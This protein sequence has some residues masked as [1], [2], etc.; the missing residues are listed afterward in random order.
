M[1]IIEIDFT[2]K[3]LVER[4]DRLFE[5]CPNAFI[6]QS[7]YWSNVIKDLG[8][9]KPIFLLCENAG[10]DVAAL[11]LYLYEHEL[12]NIM[13]SIP[14]PGPLGGI[15][16]REDTSIDKIHEIYMC[17]LLKA[18]EIAQH[19][20]CMSLTFITN[21]F[22]NDIDFYEKYLS[23]EFVFENFTQYIPLTQSVH[24]SH[25]HR[26]NLNKAKKFGFNVKFCETLEEL[27]KWYEIHNKRH[28]EIGTTP[29]E[30][31]LFENMFQQLVTRH[32]AQLVLVKDDDEIASG[33]FYIYHRRVLDV[34]MLSLNSEYAK[35]APNYSN[36]D[37][38]VRWAKELGIT[39]F[40]WQSSPNKKC[41]VYQYKKQWG[42]VDSPYYF[43]TK[44]L[45]D[46]RTIQEIGIDNLK[47]QY[48][49]HYVLPYEVFKKGFGKKYFKKE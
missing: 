38:S 25:G 17:L 19:N 26:N 41:G 9:D 7:T 21:P 4:Y 10:Q 43:V 37:Y 32:K 30:Y 6:Q 31:C 13:T 28:V 33:A 16:H 11:P 47:Q 12:G 45:C 20:H 14:Q 24:R 2:D 18:V 8:P 46:P 15:F 5:E 23:P 42:S 44:I 3:R 35:F 29:L 34:F 1:Q 39:I 48:E 36:T 40:N 22:N 27:R 49:W